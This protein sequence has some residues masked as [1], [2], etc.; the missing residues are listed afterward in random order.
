MATMGFDTRF[1]MKTL[2]GI[3]KDEIDYALL[4]IPSGEL[5]EK[6]EK[7]L[8]DME[9]FLRDLMGLDYDVL[10]INIDDPVE[11]IAEIYLKLDS[12][13]PSMII[14]DLSGGMRS[15]VLEAYTAILSYHYSTGTAFKIIVWKED[16]TGRIEVDHDYTK[17]PVLMGL[18]EK[19]I[20]QLSIPRTLKE[21]V[22]A[23]GKPKTTVYLR[24][25]KLINEGL[26]EESRPKGRT[27]YYQATP[28][29]LLALRILRRT[30]STG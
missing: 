7:A 4:L 27:V 9:G 3:G 24:L 14:G 26:V 16:L 25:R 10:K 20:M 15:M 5:N 22:E 1:Q 23:T 2:V 28:K 18:D 19:I 17:I 21:I 12:L 6:A 11:A 13:R 8:R 30:P 29:A